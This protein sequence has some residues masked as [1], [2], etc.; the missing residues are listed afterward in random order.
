M[1]LKSVFVALLVLSYVV[2]KGSLAKDV[3]DRNGGPI[4]IKTTNIVYRA[5]GVDGPPEMERS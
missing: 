4:Q 2:L 5:D 3:G 1:R